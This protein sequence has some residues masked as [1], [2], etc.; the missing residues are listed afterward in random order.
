MPVAFGATKV[1]IREH[2][3]SNP[4]SRTIFFMLGL[5]ADNWKLQLKIHRRFGV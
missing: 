2:P 1:L 4:G 5:S 3:G